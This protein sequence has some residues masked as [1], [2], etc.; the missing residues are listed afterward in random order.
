MQN[1]D[2][3]EKKRDIIKHKT[4]LS[5]IK[6]GKK[7]LTFGDIDIEKKKFLLPYGSYIFK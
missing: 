7:I 6:R 1:A 4:L 2:L 5:N 3:T